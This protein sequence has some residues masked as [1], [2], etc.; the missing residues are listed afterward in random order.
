MTRLTDRIVEKIIGSLDGTNDMLTSLTGMSILE[1][2]CDA[3]DITPDEIDLDGIRV[4][5]VPVTSGLGIIKK[6]S[7]SVAEIARKL[8][9]EAFVTE[10]AD[11]AGLAEALSAEVDIVI[12]ADDLKFIAINIS[13][14]RFS[15]NSFAT[16]AGYVSALKGAA[17]GLAGKD[18][19]VLGAGR[20]GSIAAELLAAKGACVTVYDIDKKRTEDL[21]CRM[22]VKIADDAESAL[23]SHT[24]VLNAS[25]AAIDGRSVKEGTIF[26]SPGLP[27]PFDEL[28]LKKAKMVI[29]DPLEIGVAVM[30]VQSASFSRL[31]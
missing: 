24:L 17:G 28:G 2:A 7:E 4:G 18:V 13:K 6:F 15:H 16:A 21:L 31:R 20:V 19:L 11:V 26:S 27:F 29:H 25:P 9:M 22:D 12:M 3:I 30:A 1:L 23:S 10:Y 5:V 14:G 8:G